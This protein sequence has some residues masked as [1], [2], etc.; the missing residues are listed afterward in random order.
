[1]PLAADTAPSM[2]TSLAARY[3]AVR[4]ATEDLCE[5]LGPEDHNLQS[6]PDASPAKWHLA[7]TTWFFETFVL[8]S[9]PGHE[10]FHPRYNFL[11]NSYY[12]AVGPR[13]PRPQRGLLSR[14]TV[15]E[16]YRYRAAVDERVRHFLH[17][18]N[19]DDVQAVARV[20]ELGLHHEQQHQELLLTDL[21]HAFSLNPLRPAYR[22]EPAPETVPLSPPIWINYPS[23]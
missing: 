20:V 17:S 14:P 10:P 3:A 1:M 9:L 7:H 19:A 18:A 6:M 23:G 5:P 13:H 22:S 15:E 12:E 16:V 11:F 21:K 8:A 4:R 2:G